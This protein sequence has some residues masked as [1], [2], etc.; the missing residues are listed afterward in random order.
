MKTSKLLILLLA[1]TR[2]RGERGFGLLLALLVA[3]ITVSSAVT[4]VSRTQSGWLGVAEQSESR[5]AREA[6]EAGLSRVIGELNLP[7]NRRLLVNPMPFTAWK[8]RAGNGINLQDDPSLINPCSR[9]AAFP[10]NHPSARDG[11]RRLADPSLSEATIQLDADTPTP[12]IQRRFLLRSVRLSDRNRS[13]WYRSTRP[14]AGGNAVGEQSASNFTES[15]INFNNKN[16]VGAIELV[17][18]GQV[19]KGGR[20]VATSNLSREYLVVPKC[21]ARSFGGPDQMYGNDYRWCFGYPPLAVGLANT[22]TNSKGGIYVYPGAMPELR[23]RTNQALRPSSILCRVAAASGSQSCGNAMTV[24]GVAVKTDSLS[25]PPLP[26]LDNNGLPCDPSEAACMES[27]PPSSAFSIELFKHYNQDSVDDA[28]ATSEHS[29]SR[30]YLRVLNGEVQF[31]NKQYAESGTKAA[32]MNDYDRTET[33][34]AKSCISLNNYCARQVIEGYATYHCRIK[35]IYVNDFGASTDSE[36]RQNNTLFIDTSNGPIYLYIYNQWAKKSLVSG[37]PVLQQMES[38]GYADDFP[39]SNFAPIYT[40]GGYNDGQIQHVRCAPYASEANACVDAS[41]SM[42]SMS[43]A[44]IISDLEN[45]PDDRAEYTALIG[46]DGFVR[47]VFFWMPKASLNLAG[48]PNIFD[49]GG[50]APQGKPQLSAGLWLN[51][52]RFTLRPT[53]VYVPSENDEFFPYLRSPN[54]R[55][56][57]VI[58]DWVA[59]SSTTTSLFQ[60]IP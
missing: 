38:F 5:L 35:N 1:R 15:L 12:G 59:R 9:F 28:S 17:V 30:D 48:D 53:Q 46:D 11:L 36:V 37:D 39:P 18:Q 45:T 49:T 52:L 43:R 26:R 25:F 32:S 50:D 22:S 31:C 21:C 34:L 44:A 47:D 4:L 2:A 29:Y 57:A 58:F 7:V 13:H 6:A 10:E 14:Q 33:I 60:L 40:V 42:A 3:L 51:V 54:D 16:N 41:Q 27:T 24:D 19:L 55:L 20:V 8:T 23:Q 56:R